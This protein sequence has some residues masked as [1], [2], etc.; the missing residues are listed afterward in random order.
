L[1]IGAVTARIRLSDALVCDNALLGSLDI[2]R[3]MQAIERVITG[4]FDTDQVCA[5]LSAR[6]RLIGLREGGNGS[7]QGDG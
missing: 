5:N 4:A 7:D 3:V 1:G 6:Q 2:F